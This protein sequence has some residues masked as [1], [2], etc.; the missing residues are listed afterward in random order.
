MNRQGVELLSKR[1]IRETMKPCAVPT[2]ITLDKDGKWQMCT[3]SGR[4]SI[5]KYHNSV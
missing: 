4:K 5:E 1:L 2:L 3:K